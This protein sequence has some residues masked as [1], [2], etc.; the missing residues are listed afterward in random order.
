L[1]FMLYLTSTVLV[2]VLQTALTTTGITALE[3]FAA[4]PSDRR[5][6]QVLPRMPPPGESAGVGID[7]SVAVT[8]I[9][10]KDS[11]ILLAIL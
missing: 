7:P 10:W 8:A 6:L 3:I 4:V 11:L 9:P 2:L 1:F 5:A